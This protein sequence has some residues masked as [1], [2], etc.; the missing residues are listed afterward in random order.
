MEYKPIFDTKA[1][2][3]GLFDGTLRVI[4]FEN[5]TYHFWIDQDTDE[6]EDDCVTC[7]ELTGGQV[8]ELIASLTA[9]G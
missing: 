1:K 6:G 9:N 5:G 7:V 3:C 8:K 4:K 2:G